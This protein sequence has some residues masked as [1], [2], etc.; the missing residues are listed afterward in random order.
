M[1]R[2]WDKLDKERKKRFGILKIGVCLYLI[3][4]VRCVSRLRCLKLSGLTTGLHRNRRYEDSHSSHRHKQ[5]ND[6]HDDKDVQAA[7]T[8][9]TALL[10]RLNVPFCV[11]LS[12]HSAVGCLGFG[13]IVHG[14]Q[15]LSSADK[16]LEVQMQALEVQLQVFRLHTGIVLLLPSPRL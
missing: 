11:L 9:A 1:Q 7:P 10:K 13:E 14:G 4:W 3:S 8:P 16:R 2:T 6:G 15:F 5:K 12:H